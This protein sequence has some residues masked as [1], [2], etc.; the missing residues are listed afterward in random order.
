MRILSVNLVNISY[1]NAVVVEAT[2]N[3]VGKSSRT[4]LYLKYIVNLITSFSWLKKRI[5]DTDGHMTICTKNNLQKN[6]IMTAGPI[7]V[8]LVMWSTLPRM[9]FEND[10]L[11]ILDADGHMTNCI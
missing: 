11:P 9:T 4:K 7:Q 6:Q 1:F 2:E 8:Q 3:W 5:L 10:F